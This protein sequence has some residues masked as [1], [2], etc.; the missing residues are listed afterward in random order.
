MYEHLTHACLTTA[1]NYV[2]QRPKKACIFVLL[3]YMHLYF[4]YMHSVYA[5]TCLCVCCVCILYCVITSCESPLW[6]DFSSYETE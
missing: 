5:C 4:M 1:V 3:A 6:S 2:C